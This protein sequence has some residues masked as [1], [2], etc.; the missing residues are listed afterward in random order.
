MI[1]KGTTRRHPS[2][3]LTDLGFA[4]DITLFSDNESKAQAMLSAIERVALR[5]GLK[6][7]RSKTEFMLVGRWD[8]TPPTI[9][10]A[11]G[12]LRQV[13]D[14]KYLGSWLR[15]S[16]KD[17][18]VREAL[19]WKA[20][21]RLVKVWKSKIV[22]RAV[23]LKLFLACVESTLLYNAV[24]WTMTDTLAKALDGRYTLMLRYCMGYTWRDKVPN[25]ILYGKL[26]KVSKR[27]LERKLRFAGHCMRATDQPVSELLFWDHT[28]MTGSKCTK[29]AGARPNYAKRLLQECGC[30]V[31][32]DTELA[33]L[34]K[35]RE[36]WKCRIKMIVEENCN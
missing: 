19:A 20:C 30:V 7:N 14:F 3:Y 35:D 5:V 31:R 34:M 27:L 4:D 26:P 18:K 13:D 29:G 9:T 22:T 25:T 6:I 2:K 17:F 15:D 10:L 8:A 24:T 16:M 28:K 11:S 1:K 33:N 32:S 23:K 36:E 21:T 12:P